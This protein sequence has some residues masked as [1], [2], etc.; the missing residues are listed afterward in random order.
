LHLKVIFQK[1]MVALKK[2]FYYPL[3]YR[4]LK[5]VMILPVATSTIERAFSA[6]KIVKSR[7]CNQM[8]DDWMNDCLVTY[9]ERDVWTKLM[10]S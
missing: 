6:M 7:L 1:K 9:I 4:L 8:G 3:V 10:M 5:L 2:H